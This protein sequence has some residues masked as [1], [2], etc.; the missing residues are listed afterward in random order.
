[1]QSL[2]GS[3]AGNALG[4]VDMNR[5]ISNSDDIVQMTEFPAKDVVVFLYGWHAHGWN[6]T[7]S[8]FQ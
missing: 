2:Q 5:K 7:N 3:A 6:Q 1:M 4:C 8:L